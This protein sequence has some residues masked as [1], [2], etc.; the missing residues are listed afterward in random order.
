M[1]NQARV[2]ERS[3]WLPQAAGPGVVHLSHPSGEL[4]DGSNAVAWRKHA[5]VF[6]LRRPTGQRLALRRFLDFLRKV[7]RETALL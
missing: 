2:L 1:E 5:P 3:N 6:R 7:L 4:L